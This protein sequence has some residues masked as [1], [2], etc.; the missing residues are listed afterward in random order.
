MRNKLLAFLT[1]LFSSICQFSAYSQG[2]FDE[3]SFLNNDVYR[4]TSKS[5]PNSYAVIL[6]GGCRKKSN[7]TQYWNNCAQTYQFLTNVYGFNPDHIYT[8]MADGMDRG[9]ESLVYKDTVTKAMRYDPKLLNETITEYKNGKYESYRYYYADGSQLFKN[10]YGVNHIY[11]AVY[12][13]IQYV[14]DKLKN[15]QNIDEL[16]VFVTDHGYI[17]SKEIAIWNQGAL[18]HTKF[19]NM[20]NNIQ[21]NKKTILLAQCFSGSFIEYLKNDDHRTICTATS[22]DSS[23]WGNSLSCFFN[24]FYSALYGK[25]FDSTNKINA[26]YDQNGVVSYEEAFVYA[27]D[28]DENSKPSNKDKSWYEVPRYWTSESGYRFCRPDDWGVVN[29]TSTITKSGT[30]EAM[31]L[32]NASN[33]IKNNANVTY[34]CGKTIHLK[35]GFHVVKGAKFK[36]EIFDC[37]AEKKA[38]EAELRRLSFDEEYDEDITNSGDE[39]TGSLFVIAPNPTTGEFTIYFNEETEG[40]NSVVIMDLT[41]KVVFSANGLG[42]EASIDLGGKPQGMYI[43]QTIVNGTIQTAKLILE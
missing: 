20:I 13:T 11:T 32:L 36:T 18:S 28:H 33:V 14:F 27:K 9:A 8:I 6:N 3:Y 43:V 37:E 29:V 10:R 35:K 38:N 2:T 30:K 1:I 7:Y 26:D 39:V 42:S 17:G 34:A 40:G 31:Y 15:I 12:D 16:F 22:A 4:K 25:E 21:S 24:Q 19:A 41:G 23:S 5:S